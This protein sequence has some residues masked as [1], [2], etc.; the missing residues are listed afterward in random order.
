MKAIAGRPDNDEQELA[1]KRNDRALR[2]RFYW[3]SSLG[4]HLIRRARD[5][6]INRIAVHYRRRLNGACDAMQPLFSSLYLVSSELHVLPSNGHSVKPT[7]TTWSF[8]VNTVFAVNGERERE[9]EERSSRPRARHVYV[10]LTATGPIGC[11][12]SHSSA[13]KWRVS[14]RLITLAPSIPAVV[15]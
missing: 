13:L 8:T 14:P 15:H 1:L 3:F 11:V 7:A 10:R 5:T 6:G 12:S 2:S 4:R 9:R